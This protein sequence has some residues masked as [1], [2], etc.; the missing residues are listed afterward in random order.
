MTTTIIPDTDWAKLAAT[1]D[2]QGWAVIP[3]LLCVSKCQDLASRY[4]EASRYRSEVIMQ[5]H[6]FG[7][8]AYKYF[9]YPL[10][11]EIQA[12]RSALYVPLAGIANGWAKR[13]GNDVTFPAA[14]ADFIDQCRSVGQ[15]RPTPLL[16]KYQTGDYNCLHQDLYGDV[17]FPLQ[18]AVLLSCPQEDF[19]GREFVISEQ[20]PRM[21]SRPHVVPLSQGDAV[22]FAV[23]ERPV[24]G[25]R[26][27]YRVKLRHGV[28]EIRSGRR[29]TLG[30]IF[31]DAI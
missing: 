2:Q 1:L 24:K 9:A 29:H 18:M 7:Q 15:L 12:L 17:S 16:L 25:T 6:G 5:R 26:G 31:H 13:L 28:S 4:D 8:G 30:M 22:V 11:D 23:N 14:H 21:Q 19:T 27:D 20:R 10:P 3:A